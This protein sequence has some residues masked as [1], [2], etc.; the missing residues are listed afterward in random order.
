MP[1]QPGDVPAT[2]AD[3]SKARKKLGYNP[4]VSVKEGVKHFIDWYRNHYKV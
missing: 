2:H 1:M 4:K 3:I